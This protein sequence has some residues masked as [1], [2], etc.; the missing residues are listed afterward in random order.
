MAGLK[1]TPDKKLSHLQE[2]FVLEYLKD[3]NATQAC[4]RA[5]YCKANPKNADKVGPE[6]LKKPQVDQAI[7]Q[8]MDERGARTKVTADRVILEVERMAMFDPKD[9]VGVTR[10]EEIADLPENVRRA[11]VGWGFSK[12]G[13]FS[14]KLA[15]EKAIEL[16]C[17]H[18]KLL[19]EKVEHTGKDGGPIS[20]Q[21]ASDEE[22]ERKYQELTSKLGLKD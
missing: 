12:D 13:L 3:L 16:L 1:N 15:K 21:N 20:L 6:L 17:K 4:L 18:H 11:I 22:L 5:G 2:L 14:I 10:P 8:A 9:L 19:T 7:K